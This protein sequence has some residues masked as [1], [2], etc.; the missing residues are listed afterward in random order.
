MAVITYTQEA[1]LGAYQTWLMEQGVQAC[2]DRIVKPQDPPGCANIPGTVY[3]QAGSSI[4]YTVQTTLTQATVFFSGSFQP[5]SGGWNNVSQTVIGTVAGGADQVI[6]PATPGCYRTM[7][8]TVGEAVVGGAEVYVL[9]ELG[10]T[11]N[12]QFVPYAL[13]LSGY[14]RSNEPIDMGPGP[15]TKNPPT[16]S[17]GG[18]CCITSLVSDEMFGD[19]SIAYNF[20]VPAG[21]NARIVSINGSLQT[22]GTAGNRLVT[23]QINNGIWFMYVA[24]AQSVQTANTERGYYFAP[25]SP[26]YVDVVTGQEYAPLP[27]NLWFDA[28]V[29]VVIQMTGV[30][31]GDLL[32]NWPIVYE[33][34]G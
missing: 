26:R 13:L 1:V 10:R 12:G 32:G 27:E 21:K 15:G 25:G 11:D 19:T 5:D 3:A 17:G 6:R 9:A 7:V 30:K 34:R 28:T 33:L 20:T 16:S 23:L 2:L 31:T 24:S 22:S 29:N 8:A 14:I 4:R 18:G